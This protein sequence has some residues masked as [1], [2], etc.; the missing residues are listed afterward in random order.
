MNKNILIVVENLAFGNKLQDLLSQSGFYTAVVKGVGGM[1]GFCR[2]YTPNMIFLDVDIQDKSIWTSVQVIRTYRD[3]ANLPILGVSRAGEPE[4]LQKVQEYGFA[5]LIPK[6]IDSDTLVE[7]VESIMVETKEHD[8]ISTYSR[9]QR[10]RELAGEVDTVAAN[11]R[12]QI[13]EFGSESSE[14]FG[15]V[16]SSLDEISDQ[17]ASISDTDLTDKTLRHELRNMVGTVIGFSE[18]ILRESGL[19]PESTKNLARIWECSR[20]FIE[21]LDQQK[22]ELIS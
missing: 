6:S 2:I 10:L 21:L 4:T 18:L 20:E 16:E 12:P 17:L 5:G 8:A 22:A 19:S 7:T 1:L 11:V 13:N 9:L 3:L 14:V 15:Y